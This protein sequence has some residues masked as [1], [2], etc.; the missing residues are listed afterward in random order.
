M[1]NSMTK[2]T[3]QLC[4]IFIIGLLIGTGIAHVWKNGGKEVE[5]DATVA[6]STVESVGNIK[7]ATTG[8]SSSRMFSG[9]PAN[10]RVGISVSDQTAG[11]SVAV[12]DL[13]LLENH[14]IVVY[15]ESEAGQPGAILGAVRA[16]K[17]D[18]AIVVPLLRST[19]SGKKYYVGM[20]NDSGD[21]A[22]DAHAD[23]LPE[24]PL[25]VSFKAL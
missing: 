15:E 14:W 16:H 7:D 4:G 18:A 24:N 9:I 5:D 25:I 12:T 13:A 8:E 6:T 20:T 10:L 1:L 17:E 22:F 21:D 11:D 3:Q 19:L 23:V 2:Q